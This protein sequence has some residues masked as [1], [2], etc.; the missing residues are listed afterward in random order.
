MKTILLL[1]YS[2]VSLAII[3]SLACIYGQNG[4]HGQATNNADFHEKKM[5]YPRHLTFQQLE[6]LVATETKTD[7]GYTSSLSKDDDLLDVQVESTWNDAILY[8][9]TMALNGETSS[10]KQKY[11]YILCHN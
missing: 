1:L 7:F 10:Q 5:E 9:W 2:I 8:E 3:I 11:P 4:N 6:L